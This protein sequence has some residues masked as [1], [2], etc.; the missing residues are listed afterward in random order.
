MLHT[1]SVLPGCCQIK[2]FRKMKKIMTT[3]QDTKF[4]EQEGSNAG[5]RLLAA[6]R[7]VKAE[8]GAGFLT[9]FSPVLCV[10]AEQGAGFL[11][12]F[13]TLLFRFSAFLQTS[14]IESSQGH[15]TLFALGL[16]LP[17]ARKA[18]NSGAVSAPS[19][20]DLIPYRGVGSLLAP[21]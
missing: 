4:A 6:Q 21:L 7:C 17:F 5:V 15:R 13:L 14:L 12:C 2:F 18:I 10:K 19:L 9:V 8:Q 11:T 16:Y 1:L 20:V 3:S